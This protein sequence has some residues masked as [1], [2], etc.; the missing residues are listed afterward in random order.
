MPK[1]ASGRVLLRPHALS[2]S[3]VDIARD[4]LLKRCS[5]EA[6]FVRILAGNMIETVG[7][8]PAMTALGEQE[9]VLDLFI[10]WRQQIRVMGRFVGDIHTGG[11]RLLWGFCC[12]GRSRPCGS[13]CRTLYRPEED[14]PMWPAPWACKRCW[15][16]RHP[17]IKE[18]RRLNDI[19]D[20]HLWAK[21]LQLKADVDR[22]VE[23]VDPANNKRLERYRRLLSSSSARSR[24]TYRTTPS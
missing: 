13:G 5:R 20:A 22:L 23:T 17:N 9:G 11:T 6:G 4:G 18:Q 16:V 21:T 10:P 19:E 8:V 3:V 12:P 24:S 7:F 2:F 1:P 15:R 14:W